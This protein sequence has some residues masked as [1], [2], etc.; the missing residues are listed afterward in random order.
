MA[1][2]VIKPTMSRPIMLITP[3]VAYKGGRS[4]VGLALGP[5]LGSLLGEALGSELGALLA[6]G[7]SWE[8]YL[9]RNSAR[10]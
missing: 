1:H 6:L 3:L 7:L 9:V 4:L 5:E 10:Y 8:R 2:T